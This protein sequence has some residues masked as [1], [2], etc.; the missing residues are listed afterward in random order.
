M[1]MARL[2]AKGW[3][4]FCLFAAAHAVRFALIKGTAP[5]EAAETVGISALLFIAM[6]L[7]FVG[8]YAAASDHSHTPLAER[9]K[10]SHFVPGFDG[11][12]FVLFAILSFVDQVAV[13]PNVMN[14][15]AEALH[16]AIRFAVPG[17]RALEATLGCGL[18]EGRIFAA[19][20]TWLLAII[21]L[22]QALTRVRLTAGLIRLERVKR[23][24]ALGPTALA[25]LLGFAAV[26]GFQL[27]Y[28]GTGFLFLP[29]DV[30]TEI[31]GAIVIGL[32]P[33]MLAYLIV[34]AV[35]NLLAAGPK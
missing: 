24:E 10:P 28:M 2:L 16:A 30:Y 12:A 21:Y 13:A 9:L 26:A 11:V 17:Q 35:A 25:A 3:V 14:G 1:G 29:C 22:A 8:G 19:S 20:F 31:P 32:A 18:D 4:V 27:L 6:G 33:L 7:L 15:A 5:L 23:P 34:A